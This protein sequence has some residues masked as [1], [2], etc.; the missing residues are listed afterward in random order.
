MVDIQP[1]APVYIGPPSKHSGMGNKP[2]LR[3]VI[4]SAVCPC[5]P[6]WARKIAKYFM[7]QAAGGSAQYCVDPEET[8]Q[9]A[10]D[11]LI[12]WHAPPNPGSIGVE[13]CDFPGPVPNDPPGS[14][15]FKAA[16]RA[17]RWTKPRQ[18]QMLH[19]TARL[20]AQLC[21][22]YDVPIRW[23]SP[24]QLRK[25][26]GQKQGITSHVNVSKAFG[27]STHWDP[28]FWPRR[29]FMRLVKK[30]AR[31]IEAEATAAASRRKK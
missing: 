22:A 31:E 11:S 18:Q 28:G 1:P 30:Y 15:R 3:I 17:W 29:R 8:I 4:H 19:R 16:R 25:N 23:Q 13:M 21:L 6:G 7:T 20:T 10:W 9:S 5:E 12:C 2:I 26:E 14:A 27:Q 24:A